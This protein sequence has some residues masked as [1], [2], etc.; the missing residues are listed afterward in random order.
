METI[1]VMIAQRF[2]FGPV[3]LV[4]CFYRS[5]RLSSLVKEINLHLPF[6]T[7]YLE[8]RSCL[9]SR[10]WWGLFMGHSIHRRQ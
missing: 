1:L 8:T 5:V 9:L 10:G 6:Q 7:M 2:Q 4:F 3:H